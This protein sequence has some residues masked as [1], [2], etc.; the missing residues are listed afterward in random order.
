MLL[1][2]SIHPALVSADELLQR[3]DKLNGELFYVSAH[4]VSIY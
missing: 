1:L 3:K 2:M 4:N